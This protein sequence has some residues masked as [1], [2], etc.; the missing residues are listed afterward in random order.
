VKARG[1]KP[2]EMVEIQAIAIGD[3]ALLGWAGEVFCELGMMAKAGSPYA[4]TY[5]LGYANDSVGYIPT[6]DAYPLGGYEVE[7]ALHLADNAGLVLVERSLALLNQ[8]R[9]R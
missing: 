6:P 5:V 2:V 8:M 4:R 3:L 7:R 9:G 1:D